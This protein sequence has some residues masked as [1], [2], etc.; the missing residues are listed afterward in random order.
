MAK[1]FVYGFDKL[2][3]HLIVRA[4]QELGLFGEAGHLTSYNPSTHNLLIVPS[5]LKFDTNA[6]SSLILDAVIE[7]GKGLAVFYVHENSLVF[8]IPINSLL[9]NM[10]LCFTYAL[11]NRDVDSIETIAIPVDSTAVSPLNLPSL[12]S[13]LR[14]LLG[15]ASFD[16][17]ELETLV[18]SIRYYT[19]VCD[20]RHADLLAEMYQF[21]WEY[22]ERTN[23]STD[24]GLF[25]EV[26][27]GHVAILM[28]DVASVLPADQVESVPDHAQFP[29][30]TG[31]VGLGEF[32]LSL[33]PEPG[34]WVS[35]GLWLPAGVTAEIESQ[36]EAPDLN[37]QIGAQTEDLFEKDGPYQRWPVTSVV[38][39]LSFPKIKIGSMF[40]GMIYVTSQAFV[41]RTGPVELTFRNVCKY[42]RVVDS[43]PKSWEETK[44][45]P[46]PWGEIVIGP[47]TFT[48][49]TS[50]IGE[51]GNLAA[52]YKFYGEVVNG[53][54]KFSSAR[55]GIRFRVVFDVDMVESAPACGY[56]L[57]FKVEDIP[58][59]LG[60]LSM[61]TPQLF[62]IVM[63]LG[64]LTI[65]ENCFDVT[66][67]MAIASVAASAVFAQLFSGFDPKTFGGIALPPLFFV[68][69]ELHTNYDPALLPKTL[70]TFQ[71]PDYPIPEIPDDMWI[72]FVK[73]LC[74]KGKRNFT[75]MLDRIH[76]IPLNISNSLQGLQYYEAFT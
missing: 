54:R 76:P 69:W 52:V 21:S 58:R 60:V 1:A 71:D 55:A 24:H 61:P 46:V 39:A 20:E 45:L 74:L 5:N 28:A 64:I 19:L 37:I 62:V 23:Y 3:Q 6:K 16:V 32:R 47:L 8:D 38:K 26:A 11:L 51:I 53:L 4:V 65:R 73:E 36:E 48:L 66:T 75:R 22:L 35:T 44:G 68:L 33:V 25:P 59:L 49:P 67:Q 27:Q 10:G 13:S 12:V 56:P 40:G 31:A 43:D 50:A 41:E 7:K 17:S 29:G 18:R 15:R 9:V 42:P 2:T 72:A 63:F 30:Q 57:V 70:A 34:A 14:S